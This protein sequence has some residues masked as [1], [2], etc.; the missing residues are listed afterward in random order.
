M[1]GALAFG[2]AGKVKAGIEIQRLST[3]NE[4]LDRLEHGKVPSRVVIDF[5]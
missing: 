1:A 5:G 4:T 2:A 3:I